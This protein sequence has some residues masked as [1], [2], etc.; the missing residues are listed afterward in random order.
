MLKGGHGN[1]NIKY[2][3]K[4][5]LP[6]G[7]NKTYDNYVRSGHIDCHKKSSD[8]RER[9]HM[10]F[11]KSWSN[12]KIKTAGIHVANLK[13]NHKVSDHRPMHGKYDDVDVVTYK[14]K[15]RICGI[16]PKFMKD[17]NKE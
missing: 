7:I 10:W 6:F 13:K 9:G 15:G 11:P 17:K 5:K 12:V 16:C 3:E 1:D 2:L 14:S 4:H 8:R